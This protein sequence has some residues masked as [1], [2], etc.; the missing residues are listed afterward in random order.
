MRRVRGYERDVHG[1][2]H[3]DAFRGLLARGIRLAVPQKEAIGT[4]SK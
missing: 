2:R 3:A 4:S 1:G